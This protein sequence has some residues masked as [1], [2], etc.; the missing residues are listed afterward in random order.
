[1]AAGG[2]PEPRSRPVTA[3]RSPISEAS[4]LDWGDRHAADAVPFAGL[5]PSIRVRGRAILNG[6]GL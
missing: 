1:M 4:L 2:V 3:T 6:G 5:Q